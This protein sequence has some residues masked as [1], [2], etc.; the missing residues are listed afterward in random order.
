[1]PCLICGNTEDKELYPGIKTCPDCAFARADI[2]LS[3]A[4]WEALYNKDYFFGNEY[5]D[6]L[7]EEQPL[8]KNFRRNLDLISRICGRGRLFEVGCAYGF[9][10]HEASRDYKVTG[11]DIHEEGCRHA[12]EKFGLDA[13]HGNFLTMPIDPCSA[14]IIAMWDML[15]HVPDPVEFLSRSARVLKPGGH[16]FLSTLDITSILSRLQG[17]SWRQIHPPTHVSYFSQKALRLALDHAGFDILNIRYLGEYR[18]WNN[19]W[20]N[21]LVL[22]AKNTG[23]YQYLKKAGLTQGE[24]YLNTFDHVFVSAR[25][26]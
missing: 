21:L 19:T 13:R 25:K 11:I 4:E 6:Y 26:R 9:F 3:S 7:G 1:M 12:R 14:D 16:L 17:R 23:A 2:R 8:R 24:Y 18:S 20:F 15:E 10:L 5:A 22:R